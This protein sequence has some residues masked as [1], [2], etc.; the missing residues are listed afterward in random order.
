MTRQNL[1]VLI[2]GAAS[3]LLL[4]ATAFGQTAAEKASVDAAKGRGEVGEQA[5][6][7]LGVR[8][9]ADSE[10]RAAVASINAG[11]AQVYQQAAQKNGVSPA[12]AGA[13]AF[14]EVIRGRI[15]P[16]EYY[17]DADGGWKRK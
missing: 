2:A 12:A 16:G 1:L 9:N 13:A 8:T 15:A 5:D 4:G 11:R 17:K 7:F 6:G 10:V 14:Q 3:A